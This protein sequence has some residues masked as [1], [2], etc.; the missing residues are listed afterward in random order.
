MQ[1]VVK[2][3]VDDKELN[4]IL[5]VFIGAALIEH[6]KFDH[7]LNRAAREKF[8]SEIEK[9]DLYKEVVIRATKE[10]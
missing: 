2:N 10:N 3:N 7:K 6:T 9:T 4:E 1:K 8:I 5:Q